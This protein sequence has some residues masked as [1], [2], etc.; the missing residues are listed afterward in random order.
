MEIV[1]AGRQVATA[2][3]RS[4]GAEARRRRRG[5]KGLRRPEAPRAISPLRPGRSSRHRLR[6]RLR[7]PKPADT[8]ASSPPRR[9]PRALEDVKTIITGSTTAVVDENL[10]S[11]F[12]GQLADSARHCR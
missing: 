7:N 3:R 8:A 9:A 11:I 5:P 10:A 2:S 1:N 12:A 4:V 6:L